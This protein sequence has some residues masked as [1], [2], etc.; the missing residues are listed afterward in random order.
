[1][2]TVTLSLPEA[3]ALA[4]RALSA[5]GFSEDHAAAVAR[6]VTGGERDGCASHGLWRLLGID[7]LRKGKV[8]RMPN[9]RLTI[10]RRDCARRCRRRAAGV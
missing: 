2:E 8:S 10:G 1:M 7:T 4:M 6:N 5:N 3:Y 9:R